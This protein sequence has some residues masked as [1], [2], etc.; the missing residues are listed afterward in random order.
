MRRN[1]ELGAAFAGILLVTGVYVGVSHSG[2]LG[3]GT[4][5]G[6]WI[7]IVGFVFMLMTETLYSLRKQ[8]RH[9]RWG[10]M[11]T[12]LSAHIFTGI[13][14]PY[15]VF[16]HTGFQFG[17]LA[18]VAMWL[19]ATVVVS[20]FIGRYVYTTLPR[21]SAGAE[22]GAPQ[23]ESALRQAQTRLDA[24]LRAH[25]PHWQALASEMS[26]LPVVSGTSLG[27][28]LRQPGID[29]QYRRQW[30]RAVRELG[31]AHRAQAVDLGRLLS[32]R[33]ALQRQIAMLVTQRRIMA[34]WHT[35]HVPLGLVLFTVA[36]LHV[37]AALFYSQG[38][39]G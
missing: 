35:L 36:F 16:L 8:S 24:W 32:K 19:T 33:R 14:G 26:D 20:G 13:V 38:V 3:A 17:G 29:R 21:T 11:E 12:W 34:V 5:L 39:I 18:G 1:V 22:M 9:I 28:V 6:H 23:L 25:S 15:M 10:P 4:M 37:V 30:R 31:I 7:G 27:S 2:P